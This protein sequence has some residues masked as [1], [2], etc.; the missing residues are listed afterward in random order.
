MTTVLASAQS[1]AWTIDA[2]HSA[3]E[4]SAKHMMITTVKGR[5]ADVRGTIIVDAE[6]PDRSAVE[7]ELG[8]ASIDTRS[9][10]R[11][12]HLRSADFLDAEQFPTI[13]FRSRRIDEANA[14]IGAEFQVVGDLT[15]RGTTR[16]V[17]LDATY[18]GR[19]RDPWGGERMSFSATTKIDRR[20]F[21]LT[22]NAALETGGLLVSNEIKIHI[23]AQVVRNV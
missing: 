20:D 23:E 14:R 16:E 10:Q 2:A 13:T 9:E 3:T 19:G 4:F 7:V 22:W 1:T 21:G 18:E 11:D 5:I 17:M 15:I 6:N 12:T 8:A